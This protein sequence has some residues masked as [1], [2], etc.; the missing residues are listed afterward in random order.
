MNDENFSKDDYLLLIQKIQYHNSRYWIMDDPVVSDAEYDQLMAELRAIENKHPEWIIPESPTQR[1][2]G[3][4]VDKFT[5][6]QHPGPILSLANAFSE[7]DIRA[8]YERIS[9]LDQ[10][11]R[12]SKFVVEPKIDGLTVVLHY[13]NG[14]FVKGAT[15]GDGQVGEDVTM[16]LRTIR[17]I[18]LKIPLD[19]KGPN[20]PNRLVVRGE[21]YISIAS[22]EKLN[23]ELQEKGEKT[24]LNPRNTA[25]GSLRQLDPTL[26]A[27]RPLT[28]LTYDIVDADGETP[29]TQWDLLNS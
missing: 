1:V 14:R 4:S 19:S 20:P 26:T 21:A 27:S 10:R 16:N 23:Q 25:A 12:T 24:Y 6:V 2:S 9:K 15:R 17:A 5:K 29:K 13:E 22:F 11:V 18:P 3:Q 8:W 28:L 7:Q